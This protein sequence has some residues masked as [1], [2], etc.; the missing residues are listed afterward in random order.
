MNM[1]DMVIRLF[2]EDQKKKKDPNK[3]TNQETC[4]KLCKKEVSTAKEK[5]RKI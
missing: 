3:Q 1:I 4:G 2:V 5:K